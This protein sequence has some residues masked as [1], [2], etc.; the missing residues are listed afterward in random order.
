MSG[1]ILLL[2]LYASMAWTVYL[3]HLVPAQKGIWQPRT[4]LRGITS[5]KIDVNGTQSFISFLGFTR[6]RHLSPNLEP[7]ESTTLPQNI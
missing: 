1:I 3:I 4:T 5:K 2:P 6:P 7:G